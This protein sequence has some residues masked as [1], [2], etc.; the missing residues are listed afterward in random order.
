MVVNNPIS[1][2]GTILEPIV[3]GDTG[4]NKQNKKR[5]QTKFLNE[6]LT[7]NRTKVLLQNVYSMRIYF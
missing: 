1:N 2:T 7:P 4:I 5:Y 3:E 6:H